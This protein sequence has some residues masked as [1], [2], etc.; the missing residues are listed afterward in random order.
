M[1]F[2]CPVCLEDFSTNKEKWE[3]H[4]N[5]KHNGIGKDIVRLVRKVSQNSFDVEIKKEDKH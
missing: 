1:G 2:K 4:I 5:E 3:K